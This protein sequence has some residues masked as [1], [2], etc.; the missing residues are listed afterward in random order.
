MIYTSQPNTSAQ[1]KPIVAQS[2]D[3][4]EIIQQF[5]TSMGHND[6]LAL[7][8]F[9]EANN[10]RIP[11]QLPTKKPYQAFTHDSPPNSSNDLVLG[12][13][14]FIDRFEFI[15]IP[16]SARESRICEDKIIKTYVFCYL[17]ATSVVI[18]TNLLI[19]LLWLSF[20]GT[21]YLWSLLL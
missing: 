20:Q 18:S 19:F 15:F 2:R 13:S 16:K 7:S 3:S 9:S 21:I 11:S 12:D 6:S 8:A 10:L 17:M 14:C 5:I 4:R 1:A